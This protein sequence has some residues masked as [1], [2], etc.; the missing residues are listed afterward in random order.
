MTYAEVNPSRDFGRHNNVAG[1]K[2]VDVGHF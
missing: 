2:Y 1:L